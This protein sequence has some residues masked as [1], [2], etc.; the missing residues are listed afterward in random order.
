MAVLTKNLQ[1]LCRPEQRLVAAVR[2]LVVSNQL[3][4]IRL[5]PLAHLAGEQ[6][7]HQ[8]RPPQ[9]LPARRLVPGAPW[10]GGI[11]VAM[12]GRLIAL[13]VTDARWQL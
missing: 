5:D 13:R 4:G 10:L 11:A 3:R 12:A 9:T 7:A 1:I 2:H 6:V 8:D